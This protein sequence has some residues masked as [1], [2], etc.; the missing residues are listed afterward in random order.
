[1]TP[2]WA[3]E[4]VLSKVLSLNAIAL[5]VAG[6]LAFVSG[7]RSIL[8]VLAGTFL[9]GT[10]FTLCGV[11]VAT[12]I[13]SLNQFILFTVP[14]E[15]VGF[16]PAILHLFGITPSYLKYYPANACMDMVAGR[17]V[18]FVG[19]LITMALIVILFKFACNE[20]LG[21]WQKQ[22]GAKI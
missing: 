18:Q 13:N 6:V 12:K 9:S 4:Y 14:V 10:I 21:M 11:L 20:V 15:V 16:L 19:L 17:E 8:L 3:F 22:G 5:V 1:V 7:S 2:L